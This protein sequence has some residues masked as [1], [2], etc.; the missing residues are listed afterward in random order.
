MSLRE[1]SEKL[2]EAHRR[3]QQ[4]ID[5]LR[6]RINVQV[7]DADFQ[8][9]RLDLLW[10]LRDLNTDLQKH[11]DMEET[12][13][14]MSDILKVTPQKH[15]AVEKLGSEH[16]VFSSSLEGI[17]ADLKTVSQQDDAALDSIRARVNDFI[18]SLAAHESAEEKLIMSAYLQDEGAGD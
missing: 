18:S 9:W 3:L 8:Q 2:N 16:E 13:G 11:F 1:L 4:E 6:S 12:R 15:R 7:P 14:Y 17:M 10:L 5:R